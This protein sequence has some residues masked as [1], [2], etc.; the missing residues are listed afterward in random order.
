MVGKRPVVV[1]N[2]MVGQRL[3]QAV[4]NAGPIE[5]LTGFT[6]GITAARRREE[7]GAALERRGATVRYA[8][9]IR[10]VPLLDDAD[11]LAATRACL[12]EPLDIAVAMT[13]I[14]YRGWI[15]AADTW[16]LGEDL[17]RALGGATV[18]ARGPKVRGAIRASGLREAW[19]PDSESASEVL[20]YLL[21]QVELAGKRIAV[22]LHG[23]PLPGMLEALVAAGAQVIDVPVYRWVPPV[24]V[25]PLR[26]LIGSVIAREV[27]AVAFTSAPA[28]KNFLR[29]ADDDNLGDAI[30]EALQKDVIAACVG[31]VTAGP[32][33]GADIPVIQPDR[34]RLGALV[35]EIVVQVPLR[36]GRR[37][38]VADVDV[39]VR[40]QGLAVNG[41]FC[42]LTP[43]GMALM[44]ALSE[45]PGQV[46]SRRAMLDV[47]PGDGSD[48]HTVE[49]AVARLRTGLGRP[50]LIQTVVKRGYRLAL[51]T[52]DGDLVGAP[53]VEPAV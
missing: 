2:G 47:L 24:D 34:F 9:A 22:Q 19:S 5:P 48:E 13:G 35:R 1:G 31:S 3:V 20:E 29:T 7:F 26:R 39:E 25:E 18:L 23:E 50:D 4:P 10:I 42:P 27:Q 21:T 14:G 38:R 49:V 6:I 28:S 53:A 33:H 16:G 44:K 52:D 41:T 8:P 12:A 45:R 51:P 30:R 32:L 43:A 46:V 17:L 40:G 36:C 11:L 37:I 15:E